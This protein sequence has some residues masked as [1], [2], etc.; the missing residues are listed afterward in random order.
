MAK[1]SWISYACA[2]VRVRARV[3][4]CIYTHT[5]IHIYTCKGRPKT[6]HESPEVE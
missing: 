5:H 3:D 1:Y 2:C 4:M 6:G